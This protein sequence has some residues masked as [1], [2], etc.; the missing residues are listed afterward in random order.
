MAFAAVSC[1][2]VWLL[3]ALAAD[4]TG[5]AQRGRGL[6]VLAPVPVQGGLLAAGEPADLALQGLLSSVNASVDEQVAAGAERPG[7]ELTDV[8]PGVAVQFHMFLQVLLKVEGLP[9]GWLWAGEG[10]LVDVLVLLVV[11]QVL[12]VGEDPS[13]AWEVTGQQ[14]SSGCFPDSP[15]AD[16]C[17]LLPI[18]SQSRQGR[19]PRAGQDLS[20]LGCLRGPAE[21]Q[22]CPAS[23]RWRSP[24]TQ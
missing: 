2:A 23:H 18:Q 12:P 1:N 21:C 11:I 14:L 6:H 3:K 19:T 8:V 4:L 17:I 15:R 20:L 5:E 9:T 13:A 10:L 7:A 24:R 22:L 16:L